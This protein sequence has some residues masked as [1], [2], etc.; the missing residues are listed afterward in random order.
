MARGE[1]YVQL[2]AT[3]AE[4]KDV[5]KLSRHGKDARSIRDLFVQMICYCKRTLSDGFVPDDELGVL[6]YPDPPK[7]GKR[8]ADRLVEVGLCERVE[9]GYILP[10]YLKRNKAKDQVDAKSGE[11]KDA[12]LLGNHKRW[13]VGRNTVAP[14][15]PLCEE[16]RSQSE[17]LPDRYSDTDPIANGSLPDRLNE[18]GTNPHR[19]SHRQ[20]HSHSDS[21]R[22]SDHTDPASPKPETEPDRFA[23]FWAAYP[24]RVGKGQALKA[25]RS[26]LKR[27][28]DPQRVIEAAS[29]YAESMRGKDPQYVA[30]AATWL[31]GERY[32]DEPDSEQLELPRRDYFTPSNPPPEVADD[33]QRY[34]EWYDE[35]LRAHR[36]ASA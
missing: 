11:R 33:P 13:H 16:N 9:G 20:S 15:C 24:K 12:A 5:R 26:A 10:G 18:S 31:N 2:V 17:S 4:D 8:D 28:A 30:H 1:I 3:Y 6:V 27:K 7:F 35:Q 29:S 34:A 25:W 23:D 14:G 22:Q 36:E 21:D 32:D 19:H